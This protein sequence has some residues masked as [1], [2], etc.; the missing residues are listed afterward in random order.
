MNGR[1][2]KKKIGRVYIS[3]NNLTVEEEG[4]VI[5]WRLLLILWLITG[6]LHKKRLA[7]VES[8]EG[9][10]EQHMTL[11]FDPSNHTLRGWRYQC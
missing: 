10:G 6:L 5:R 9:W 8:N 11:K 4:L 7:I 2:K 3:T 1:D